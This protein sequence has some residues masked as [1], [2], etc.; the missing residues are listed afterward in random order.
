LDFP[1]AA[2]IAHAERKMEEDLTTPSHLLSIR[3]HTASD[4]STTK[5][6]KEQGQR[7]L[8]C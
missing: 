6:T 7:R 3:I 2:V 4:S 1:L 5:P 8:P